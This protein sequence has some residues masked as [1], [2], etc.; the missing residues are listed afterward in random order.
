MKRQKGH[1]NNNSNYLIKGYSNNFLTKL[2][3]G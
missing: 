3:L 2:A 1:Q